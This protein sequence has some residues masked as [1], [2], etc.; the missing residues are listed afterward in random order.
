MI[1]RGSLEVIIDLLQIVPL[2]PAGRRPFWQ[3]PAVCKFPGSA[4]D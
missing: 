2:A 4:S 3:A 1:T